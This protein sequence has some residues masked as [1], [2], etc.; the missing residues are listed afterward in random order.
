[1]SARGEVNVFS[2]ITIGIISRKPSRFLKHVN[3]WAVRTHR[4]VFAQFAPESYL[5]PPEN[6]IP[7]SSSVVQT[8]GK[9]STLGSVYRGLDRSCRSCDGSCRCGPWLESVSSGFLRAQD[10]AGKMVENIPPGS[11]GERYGLG[12]GFW[13]AFLKFVLRAG[14]GLNIGGANRTNK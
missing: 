6:H 13:V 3:S 11:G 2:S 1:M 4:S 7:T 5:E 10:T 12:W 14:I 8:I 9:V